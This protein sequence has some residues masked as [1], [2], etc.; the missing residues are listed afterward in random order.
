M[1]QYSGKC[2]QMDWTYEPLVDSFKAFKAR[3]ILYLEDTD[4]TNKAKQATKIKI[5]LGDEGMRRI[6]AS[7]LTDEEQKKP[8]KIWNL[9]E[10]E[11]DAS[12]KINFRVHRL[13]F[14][15]MK[16]KT[17]ETISQFLSRLREKAT[18]CE[19]EAAELNERL[20]EM[21][22][23]N[24]RHEEFRKELLTKKKGHPVNE[25]L[26]RGREYEAIAASTVSLKTLSLHPTASSSSETTQ[27]T[28]SSIDAIRKH[29]NTSTQNT[30]NI[31]CPNCGLSHKRRSCPAYNDRCSACN[32]KGHWRKL[33]RKTNGG[34]T[35]YTPQ[36]VQSTPQPSRPYPGK[37]S[38]HGNYN[39]HDINFDYN[40]H[41]INLQTE[42]HS[43]E[44]S[45]THFHAITVGINAV[46][47]SSDEA[48]I[49]LQ[50][51]HPK[52]QGQL[53]IK[54]DTGSGGNTL[55][56]RTY[57]QMFGNTPLSNVLQVDPD[58]RL[59]SYSGDPIPCLGSLTLE[60][61]K[62][63]QQIATPTKFYIVD[64]SGPAIL[65]LPSCRQLNIVNLNL[66]TMTHSSET[67]DAIRPIRTIDH[68]HFLH[69]LHRYLF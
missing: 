21:V 40:Q 35:A 39:Q 57:Q 33:C 32:S 60:I 31:Q 52:A 34:Q 7:G 29:N 67:K 37:W 9:I 46:N 27:P 61:R 48:F 63:S 19:F 4:V 45:S 36:G 13:E 24:T 69:L 2:P 22:I 15:N 14:G 53:K 68:P 55:P 43:P 64:V 54:I 28:S 3:M 65:G 26:E 10:G 47:N 23:L 51:K 1:A 50:V 58:V 59:T 38:K 49:M 66:H 41:N 56:L 30:A 12:V 25:V 16:Q 5:A 6:L 42:N 62:E 8:D 17:D 18:K 44:Q 11:V 20:I